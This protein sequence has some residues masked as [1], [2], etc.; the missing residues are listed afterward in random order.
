MEI[1]R[2]FFLILLA[3]IL[4]AANEPSA[5][6]KLEITNVKAVKGKLWIALTQTPGKLVDKKPAYYKVLDVSVVGKLQTDF[7]LPVGRYA[8]AVYHDLNSNGKLDKNILGIPKEPYGF[9]NDFR[10]MFSPPDFE[11]CAI[12]LPITGTTV[13]IKLTN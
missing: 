9:S 4:L 12:T 2:N 7:D 6:L 10:P 8:V 13:I 3:S 1:I 11:D 5:K